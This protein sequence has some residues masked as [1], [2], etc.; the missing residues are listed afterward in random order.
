MLS[1]AYFLAKI[2]FDTAENEPAKNLQKFANFVNPNHNKAADRGEGRFKDRP[3]ISPR[4]PG[5]RGAEADQREGEPPALRSR[6]WAVWLDELRLEGD[7]HAFQPACFIQNESRQC[8]LR[9]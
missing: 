2:R 5:A 6:T 4:S 8:T 9:L 7:W 3:P 1:N